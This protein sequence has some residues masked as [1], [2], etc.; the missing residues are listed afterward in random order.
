MAERLLATRGGEIDAWAVAA[1]VYDYAAFRAIGETTRSGWRALAGDAGA[2]A[3]RVVATRADAI[4]L[5]ADAARVDS[6]VVA[7]WAM[8][9][10]LERARARGPVSLYLDLP[11]GVNCDAYEVWR[12]RELFLTD[13]VGRRAAR[14]AVPRRPGLGPAAGVADRAAPR[15]LSLLHPLRAPPHA[16][17]RHAARSIT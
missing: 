5:G 2:T 7:Q 17:G 6:H 9:R 10:Q 8:Q 14:R 16:G 11:V 15:S 3:R 13:A 4:A 1:G 12:H